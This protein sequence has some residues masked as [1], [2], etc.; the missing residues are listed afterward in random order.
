LKKLANDCLTLAVA[1]DVQEITD[2]AA[3][4]E[5]EAQKLKKISPAG[6]HHDGIGFARRITLKLT[7]IFRV[8]RLGFYF[9]LSQSSVTIARKP[10]KFTVLRIPTPDLFAASYGSFRYLPVLR[11]KWVIYFFLFTLRILWV[12]QRSQ[13]EPG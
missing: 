3:I 7:G 13:R 2:F 8:W 11:S 4:S 9:E 12:W 6:T 10:G 1:T 5:A